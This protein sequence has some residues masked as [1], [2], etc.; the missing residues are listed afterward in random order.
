MLSRDSWP[1]QAFT[2]TTLCGIICFMTFSPELTFDASR[3]ITRTV[4]NLVGIRKVDPD[5]SEYDIALLVLKTPR[6]IGKE[7][8]LSLRLAAGVVGSLAAAATYQYHTSLQLPGDPFKEVA[9]RHITFPNEGPADGCFDGLG[10]L[11]G[12]R[13]TEEYLEDLIS[14]I[15]DSL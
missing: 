7:A 5:G 8:T 4:D 10:Y 3:L 14:D 9:A 11:G 2:N 13:V 1:S 15:T 12:Y 6:I